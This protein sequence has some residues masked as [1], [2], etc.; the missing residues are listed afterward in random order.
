MTFS[1]S[2]R[3]PSTPDGGLP[4]TSPRD[5]DG[6]T[7]DCGIAEGERTGFEK[8]G[9][10]D[11]NVDGVLRSPHTRLTISDVLDRTVAPRLTRPVRVYQASS[12]SSQSSASAL[13]AYNC[14]RLA[15][16]VADGSGCLAVN[17]CIVAP[18]PSKTPPAIHG[19]VLAGRTTGIWRC[20]ESGIWSLVS[21]VWS[22][23]SEGSTEV[24]YSSSSDGRTEALSSLAPRASEA[25]SRLFHG[26]E[27]R[28]CFHGTEQ[29]GRL[30]SKRGD[31]TGRVYFGT[32][33]NY[34]RCDRRS[35]HEN[36]GH[37]KWWTR[38][39]SRIWSRDQAIGHSA[40]DPR[41]DVGR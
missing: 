13:P 30:A 15:S 18:L 36:T 34:L 12:I 23:E 8:V 28:G 20:L 32:L 22:L 25:P 35:V 37:V 19:P 16:V 3:L 24:Q 41:L 7:A 21:G 4:H 6:L 14:R 11:M 9:N 31:E 29:R 39:E 27:Q 38:W 5:S 26:T 1:E 40:S 2:T 17:G 10:R 33:Y